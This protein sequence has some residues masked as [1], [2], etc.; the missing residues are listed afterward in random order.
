MTTK[1]K[2]YDI[3]KEYPVLEQVWDGDLVFCDDLI[4]ALKKTIAEAKPDEA[5]LDDSERAAR[6]ARVDM[7]EDLLFLLGEGL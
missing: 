4:D 7:A 5:F 1:I 2:R 3:H 6:Q